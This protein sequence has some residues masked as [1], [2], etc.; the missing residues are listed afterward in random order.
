MLNKLKSYIGFGR[1]TTDSYIDLAT[2]TG[3]VFIL[4]NLAFRVSKGN[5]YD[6]NYREPYSFAL[7]L[8]CKKQGMYTDT[9]NRWGITYSK[10][11]GWEIG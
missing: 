1:S 7:L 5:Y 3:F 2:T 10:K 11:H 4:G 8:M 6:P 9:I